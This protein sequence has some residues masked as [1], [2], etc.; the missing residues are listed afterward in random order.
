MGLERV[1]FVGAACLARP[2]EDQEERSDSLG[3]VVVVAQLLLAL[4]SRGT[5]VRCE[6]SALGLLRTVQ[7]RRS[8]TEKRLHEETRP[9]R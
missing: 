1:V 7:N 9:P 8:R 2:Q 4:A 6:A 3:A 5:R